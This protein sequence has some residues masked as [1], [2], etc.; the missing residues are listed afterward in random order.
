MVQ[1]PTQLLSFDE[2]LRWTDGTDQS[3][4]LIDG[5]PVPLQEPNAN[6]EDVLHQLWKRLDDHCSTFKLPYT[7]RLSK[8]VKIK[9]EPGER[10]RSRKADLV[11]FAADEWQR[12]RSSP[13][14]AAAYVPPPMVVEVVS[15]NWRDDYIAKLAE[16][17]ET[18]IAEY[19]IIDY[20]ALGGTRYL[21]T[22]KLPTISVYVLVDGDYQVQGFQGN[23]PI[24][25]PT[26]PQLVLTLDD[27]LE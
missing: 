5:M 18:G 26:F 1:A 4:D 11:V 10:E 14:P 9:T 3:F 16:Y 23:S 8:Q 24:V 25:S 20:N 7:P 15:T 6:H 13:S 17:E 2:F 19:W 21:G 12:L 22:P 27:L